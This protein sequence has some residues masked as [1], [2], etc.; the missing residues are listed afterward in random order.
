MFKIGVLL[1]LAQFICA[2]TQ[3]TKKS[4]HKIDFDYCTKFGVPANS[5]VTINART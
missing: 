2:K 1:F 4:F 5:Y 3:T